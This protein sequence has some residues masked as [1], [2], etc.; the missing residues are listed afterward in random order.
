MESKQT[1]EI[2]LSADEVKEAVLKY[3]VD[4]KAVT[5]LSFDVLKEDSRI[6]PKTKYIEEPGLDPHDG[7][8]REE[9]DGMRVFITEKE[10]KGK[11]ND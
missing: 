1:T 7:F 6:V 10:A 3:L 9:F 5:V 4:K 11:A 8:R 2:I